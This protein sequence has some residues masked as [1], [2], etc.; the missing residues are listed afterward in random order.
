MK[1][2]RNLFYRFALLIAAVSGFASHVIAAEEASEPAQ[3][4]PSKA[5]ILGVPYVSWSEAAQLRYEQKEIVNPSIVAAHKMIRKYWGQDRSGFLRFGPEE[6]L[7]DHWKDAAPDTATG[8][9]DLKSWLARGVPVYVTLPLTPHAHPEA[10][11]GFALILSGASGAQERR[12]PSSKGLGRWE[13]L[14]RLLQLG[15][16]QSPPKKHLHFWQSS[17]AAARVVIG[18]DDGRKVMIVHEPSFGPAGEI[19]YEEFERMWQYNEYKYMARPPQGYAEY[20]AKR[21]ATEA[22][23]ARTPDMRAAGHYAFGYG[24]S[25]I[26]KG[27]EAEREL[28]QGLALP[29][30]GNGYRHVLAYE[31]AHHRRA[32]GRT[33]D[34]IALLRQAIEALPEAPGPY[35]LLVEIY[36]SSPQLPE[37][38]QAAAEVGQSWKS[39]FN[40]RAGMSVAL[41]TI[42]RD[43]HVVAVAP[44]RGWACEPDF[45]GSLC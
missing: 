8:L 44:Y 17:T 42:P 30:I 14:Q 39:R 34:A 35:S 25:E 27:T 43:F 24:Y 3:A 16:K 2:F 28:E 23:P 26:G 37:A 5:L 31:L 41:R 9:G 19:G 15:E 6:H 11:G 12:G 20:L 38:P 36:K 33:E 21:R 10:T 45:R 32:A 7:P 13:S 18:Y 40:T 1:T 29:G 4:L 22:Y